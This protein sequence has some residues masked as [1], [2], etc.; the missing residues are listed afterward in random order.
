LDWSVLTWNELAIS[1]YKQ[2]GAKSMH[3]WTS[4]RLT[5]DVLAQMAGERKKTVT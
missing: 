4:F 5:G 2:I 1:F 3:D